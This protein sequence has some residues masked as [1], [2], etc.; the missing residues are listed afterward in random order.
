[1]RLSIKWRALAVLFSV[2]ALGTGTAGAAPPGVPQLTPN[3][4]GYSSYG[5]P[6]DQIDAPALWAATV[7]KPCTVKAA[8]MDSG[9]TAVPDFPYGTV[10]TFGPGGS[11]LEHG[12]R[13]S[14]IIG[15][16]INNNTG[17]AGM[18][19]CQVLPVGVM[20]STDTWHS[21]WLAAAVDWSATQPGV[22]VINMSLWQKSGEP[23][24]P[25]L[26]DSIHNAEARGILIVIGAGNGTDNN[27]KGT[28][29]ASADPLAAAF[30]GD[31]GVIRVG[32]VGTSGQVDPC[33][34]YGAALADVHAPYRLA[35]DT[36]DGDWSQAGGTSFAT[37]VV[38]GIALALFNFNPA[39]TPAQVKSILVSTARN[40]VVNAYDALV[41]AGYQSPP[42]LSLT[43]RK[44]GTGTGTVD[45]PDGCSGATCTVAQGQQVVL[46]AEP[47]EGSS[48]AGWSGAP[49][50]G[51]LPE[52]NFT[53]T[54]NV[55]VTAT[56]NR[57]KVTL[58][59]AKTGAGLVASSPVGINCGA[60]CSASF[61]YGTAVKLTARPKTVKGVKY[62]LA[63]WSGACRGKSPTCVVRLK[64][65]A[66]VTAN[67]VKAKK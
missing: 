44:S 40:G 4:P 1:M 2:A 16:V 36:P 58:R 67:F 25:P 59:V 28:D 8:L 3:D 45:G 26:V 20:D 42:P 24:W 64:S 41:A 30:A 13:V 32:G 27:C 31:P 61:A 7:G 9:A 34:N 38:S 21:D 62:V 6:L 18:T 22:R 12:T 5:A 19:T 47:G 51:K 53:A 39:L 14:S 15:A 43:L 52:C 54:A 33:S 17:V 66:K 46:T 35:S 10:A 65:L 63:S 23:A 37:P 60:K 55:T 11:N 48:F 50:C 49:G 57:V 29:A 56:F